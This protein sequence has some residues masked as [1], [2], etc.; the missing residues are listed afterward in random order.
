MHGPFKTAS[1][2]EFRALGPV[3]SIRHKKNPWCTSRGCRVQNSGPCDPRLPVV[4]NS[5]LCAQRGHSARCAPIKL[6]LPT[7][8]WTETTIQ[9][10]CSMGKYQVLS[11]RFVL[12]LH[13]QAPCG[14]DQ[15]LWRSRFYV[16]TCDTVPPPL[17]ETAEE[18]GVTKDGGGRANLVCAGSSA[19]LVGGRGGG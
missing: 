18:G 1:G 6:L 10:Q 13:T 12:L 16:V 14:Y 17:G 5:R 2:A 7:S 8:C 11:R 9:M 15:P 3:A 4:E 19:W